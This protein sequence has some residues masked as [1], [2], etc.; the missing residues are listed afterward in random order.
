MSCTVEIENLYI[1]LSDKVILEDIN[2]KAEHGDFITI[3]GPNGSGKT[4]ILKTLMGFYK[5]YKGI[6]KICGEICTEKNILNCRNKLAYLP[7]NFEVDKFF[8]I[9]TKDII[10]FSLKEK[11]YKN[12]KALK[13]INE[14]NIQNLLDKPFGLLSGGEKQKTILAMI[15]LREPVILLLDEP[16]LNLDF[17]AY[18]NFLK[19]VEKIYNQK[20]LTIFLITHL[21]SHISDLSKKVIV[22]KSGKIVFSGDKKEI[23]NKKDYLEFIYD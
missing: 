12:E 13:I 9:L 14:F 10:E 5:P 21:L 2:L 15:L 22:L 3:L 11:Y 20:K 7:Q 8:P 17:L 1:K 6:I 19:I 18:K 16:N 23:F 4:T